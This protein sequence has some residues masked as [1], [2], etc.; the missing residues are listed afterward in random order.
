MAWSDAA[1]KASAAARASRAKGKSQAQRNAA[2]AVA[3]YRAAAKS[4]P[5]VGDTVGFTTP[6]GKRVAGTVEKISPTGRTAQVNFGTRQAG[7]AAGPYK[8]RMTVNIARAEY[9][10]RQ[11]GGY[12]TG[13]YG[14]KG[15]QAH[16][17]EM[18]GRAAEVRGVRG[19][20]RYQALKR[21]AAARS[22]RV[23]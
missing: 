12:E 15:K 13:Q 8:G 1:R 19:T 2:T 17:S 18:I 14:P 22:R 11:P 4:A 3:Q 6:G 9:L 7:G 10:R 21:Q 5:R 23:S 16:L 20:R